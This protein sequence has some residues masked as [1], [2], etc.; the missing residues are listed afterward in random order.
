MPLRL[1]ITGE[2]LRI[3]G[4]L[5]SPSGPR[6]PEPPQALLR[7]EDGDVIVTESGEPLLMEPP[8]EQ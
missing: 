6:P 2:G 1:R 8:R 7:T 3:T 5:P 4:P